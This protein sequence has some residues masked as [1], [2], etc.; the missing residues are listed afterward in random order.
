MWI[1]VTYL[2]AIYGL[3]LLAFGLDK[4]R[5]G[6]RKRRIPERRLLW[7]SALGGSPA[8]VLGRWMFSHKTRKRGFSA[9]L[10]MI[11]IIQAA[12]VFLM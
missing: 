3:T 5:A 2:W 7:L 1:A 4:F 8:A 11:V 6:R 10:M 9:T 12:T